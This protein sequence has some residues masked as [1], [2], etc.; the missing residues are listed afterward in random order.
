MND[1]HIIL[2]YQLQ[3]AHDI[4]LV[5]GD[6][7]EV[8]EQQLASWNREFQP[9]VIILDSDNNALTNTFSEKKRMLEQPAKALYV[10]ETL[11]D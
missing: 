5:L 1:R 7:V 10:R 8:L 4:F 3:S 11:V 6:P 9:G 2:N